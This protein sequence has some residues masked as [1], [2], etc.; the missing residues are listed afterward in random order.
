MLIRAPFGGLVVVKRTYRNGTFVEIARGDEVR[1]GMPIVDIVDT[2]AMR[3]RVRVN[4]ADVVLVTVGQTVR[5]GLDGF[6]DL[7]FNGEV[8][9]WPRS[10]HQRAVPGRAVVRDRGLDRR[11][12]RTASAGSDGVD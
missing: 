11:V 2:T 8:T 10:P 3:V 12:A 7:S 4:Q 1:P 5:V 9:R 6:P